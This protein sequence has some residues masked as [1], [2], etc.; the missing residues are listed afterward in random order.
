MDELKISRRVYKLDDLSLSYEIVPKCLWR[1]PESAIKIYL[2]LLDF[3][4]RQINE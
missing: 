3:Q 4:K 2:V 1:L